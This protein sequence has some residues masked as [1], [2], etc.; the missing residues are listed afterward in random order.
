METSYK[1]MNCVPTVKIKYGQQD[2]IKDV[3]KQ[4]ITI[5]DINER[6]NK[7]NE[8]IKAME[9]NSEKNGFFRNDEPIGIDPHGFNY[10]FTID[11]P[12]IY[13]LF[14]SMLKTLKEQ[15]N[16]PEELLPF[17]GTFHTIQNYFGGM[18]SDQDERLSLTSIIDFEVPSI[19]VLKGKNCSMCVERASVAH[20]LWLL[21]GAKSHYVYSMTP[22]FKDDDKNDAHA[23]CI[24]EENG[25]YKMFDHSMQVFQRLEGNP[26]ETILNGELL[27]VTTQSGEEIIYANSDLNLTR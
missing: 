8:L 11:D 2:E 7:T 3:W 5:D 23:F 14:I 15:Y 27:K 21:T 17:Y 9:A 20:N 4:L 1:Y 10:G 16:T 22:K 25:I 19:S 26:I 13:H 18:E 24:I 12:E 6:R